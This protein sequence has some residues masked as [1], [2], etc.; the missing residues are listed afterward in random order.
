MCCMSSGMSYLRARYFTRRADERYIG[1]LNHSAP[2]AAKPSCSRPIE[3]ALTYQ[4]PACQ[5]TSLPRTC[6]A[7]WPSDDRRVYCHDTARVGSCTEAMVEEYVPSV[8]WMTM[9]VVSGERGRSARSWLTYAV[10]LGPVWR[11]V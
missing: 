10:G 4:L 11:Y 6:W 3:W 8:L 1:S 5:A 9:L 2:V 7:M